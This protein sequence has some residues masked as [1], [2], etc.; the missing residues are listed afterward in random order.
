MLRP[1]SAASGSTTAGTKAIATR[2]GTTSQAGRA[3][4]PVSSP[5]TDRTPDTTATNPTGI[6]SRAMAA[7]PTST[8]ATSSAAHTKPMTTVG[9]GRA[10]ARAARGRSPAARPPAG[11]RR[12][13]GSTFA[14]WRRAEEP[15]SAGAEDGSGRRAERPAG[16]GG[17]GVGEA[18][19]NPPLPDTGGE[20]RS[21]RRRG[22]PAQAGPA[23]R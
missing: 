17:A 10:D 3:P 18:A 7:D 1:P 2:G 5:L 11:L 12:R 15:G 21:R 13:L 19:M 4:L 14:T 23:R 8:L 6:T 20:R 9:P 16:S 22:G